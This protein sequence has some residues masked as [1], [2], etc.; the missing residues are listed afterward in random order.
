LRE[1]PLWKAEIPICRVALYVGQKF[2]QNFSEILSAERFLPE[3]SGAADMKGRQHR[4]KICGAALLFASRMRLTH[5]P[6]R[7]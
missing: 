7:N 6:R 4:L 5:P 3:E 1:Y 2:F